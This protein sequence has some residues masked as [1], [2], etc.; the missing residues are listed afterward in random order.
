MI[1]DATRQAIRSRLVA[2]GD[3]LVDQRGAQVLVEPVQRASGY[4]FGGGELVRG[5]D[6]L[7]LVGRYRSRGDART[8]VAEGARG[9]A[10]SI[11]GADR[12]DEPFEEV[13]RLP[14]EDLRPADG[15]GEE[16]LSIEGASLLPSDDGH[17]LYVSSEKARTYPEEIAS[18]HKPGTGV[19]TIDRVASPTVPGFANA[20]AE[21]LLGP[22]A[23]AG[24]HVKDPVAF[25]TAD[26]GAVLIYCT[27][28]FTW[29]STNTAAA[30]RSEDGSAF[31]HRTDCVLSRGPVWDVA[32]TR[33]TARLPVPQVG[34]FRDLPP[35]SLYFYDGCE[36]LKPHDGASGRVKGH[37]CEE[38]SGLAWGIDS[39]FPALERLSV[40]GPRFVSP[41]GT[42]SSRYTSVLA[43]DAAL[44]ATWQ[45]SQPDES[46]PLVGHRL[47]M[48]EVER[49]LS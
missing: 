4:W 30:V 19:W 44:I 12:F 37:S 28:P 6:G 27:H 11:L 21:P 25:W 38:I 29:S 35:V 8:G 23:P 24:L 22:G 14:K 2:L 41:Y 39:Q 42:G 40:E 16:V 36:C 32:A 43:D 10:L 1:T 13:A 34:V 18:F 31:E 46:Q 26:H 33:I 9:F 15:S 47:P 5:D 45:Q 3:R 17:E 48:E 20:A 7:W 49:I